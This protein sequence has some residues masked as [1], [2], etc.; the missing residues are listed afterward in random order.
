MG[1]GRLWLGHDELM[2]YGLGGMLRQDFKY[3]YCL[4]GI[5]EGLGYA[6]GTLIDDAGGG[7]VKLFVRICTMRGSSVLVQ[8][9]QRRSAHTRQGTSNLCQTTTQA[10][11]AP[12]TRTF[13]K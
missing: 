2:G 9:N 3:L 12:K 8:F 4:R 1:Y 5:F 6:G 11:Y 7:D 13:F 10:P